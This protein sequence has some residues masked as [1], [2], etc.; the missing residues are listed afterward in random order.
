MPEKRNQATKNIN[1]IRGRANR[2][3]P[4]QRSRTIITINARMQANK[5]T[6]TSAGQQ[7]TRSRRRET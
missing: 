6:R 5:T 3:K 2:M 1:N 7:I 4:Q